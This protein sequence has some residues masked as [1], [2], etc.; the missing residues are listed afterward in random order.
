[1]VG[2][3]LA[4]LQL[5]TLDSLTGLSNRRGFALLA[6]QALQACARHRSPASLLM[7]DLDG[8]KA[9][10]DELG[11]AVGDNALIEFSDLLA[12]TFRDS[13]VIARLG[14]DEFAVLLTDTGKE[15]A[16]K[17]IERFRGLLDARNML[18]GREHALCFSVGITEWDNRKHADVAAL[19]KVADRQ[20]YE[21]KRGKRARVA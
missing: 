2:S 3:E 5:A 21:L 17:C 1:M 13:D 19:L 4:A 7:I 18:P 10:N 9:I 15:E 8:F 20:M 16:W 6:R 12:A 14:G 11:H